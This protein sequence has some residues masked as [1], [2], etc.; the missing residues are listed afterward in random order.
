MDAEGEALP[1]LTGLRLLGR[2][3]TTRIGLLTAQVARDEFR[4]TDST[5]ASALR[6]T[7]NVLKRSSVGALM[8][9]ADVDGVQRQTMGLDLR[10]RS[11]ELIPKRTVELTAAG[12]M[13][14]GPSFDDRGETWRI[15]LAWPNA[16]W[17]ARMSW[18]RIGA[19]YDPALGF[20]ALSGVDRISLSTHHTHYI[21]DPKSVLRNRQFSP[22]SGSIEL[23][24]S[25]GEWGHYAAHI[26]PVELVSHSGLWGKL[27][28]DAKGYRLSG[29]WEILDGFTAPAGEH[30]SLGAHA[31]IANGWHRRLGLF[32][33]FSEGQYFGGRMTS[34]RLWAQMKV[35]P[36]LRISTS[37]GLYWMRGGGSEAIGR[38][39]NL[40][41]R[42]SLNRSLHG[43]LFGQWNSQT[44]ETL[45]NLRIRII[46]APGA[47]AYIVLNQG[48]DADGADAG[49]S[50]Q[51]KLVWRFGV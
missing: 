50:L 14:F 13:S 20:V 7:R 43:S 36:R 38:D 2:T 39:H 41:V 42:V 21:K 25:S 47:D 18:E 31:M 37:N 8:T 26:V 3:K 11:T 32:A 23:D 4:L 44:D 40:R 45:I 1:I 12:A 6:V 49:T 19:D 29:D 9:S 51:G 16:I 15:A 17:N 24:D 48:L 35:S 5:N 30:H 10:L 28:L 46:P 34:S 33:M 22:F 27:S